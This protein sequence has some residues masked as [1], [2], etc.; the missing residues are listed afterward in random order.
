MPDTADAFR[1]NFSFPTRVVFGPGRVEELPALVAGWGKR[2]LVVSDQGV[3]R[4]GVADPVFEALKQSDLDYAVFEGIDPNPTEANVEAGVR[5]YQEGGFDFII[6]VGGGSAIDGAKA[7]RLLAT[8]EP[9]LSRY[10]DLID[11]SRHIRDDMPPLIAL[12]TTAGT[13]SEVGR[14]TVITIDERKTVLFSPHLIPT[15]ALCDPNLTVDLPS[16]ITA[17]T[18]ADALTHNVE[19]YFSK[20]YHPLCD[21]LAL[22]GMRRASRFL[23]IAFEHGHNLEARSEMMASALMGAVA[24]QK[25]LGVVHSLAHPLSSMAGVH[26]GTANA[27]LLPHALTF[28][29]AAI[30]DRIF[31]AAQALGVDDSSSGEAVV[32]RVAEALSAL[33]ATIDLPARLRD[34]NVTHSMIEPMAALAIQDGCHLSNP[35]PVSEAEMISLYEAAF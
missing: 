26:H 6:A 15:I 31:P 34:V 13:G 10:D 25:G 28:N 17:G 20:G 18:G 30:A 19:A 35:R 33:F 21:G 23:P 11:G 32:Q 29:A 5:R 1:G 4:N 2:A 14:S 27:L 3:I 12:P 7:I 22:D 24:F 16:R 8:H 9:P